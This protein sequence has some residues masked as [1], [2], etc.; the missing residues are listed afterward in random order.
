[1]RITKRACE[2]LAK[3]WPTATEGRQY[4]WD[5]TLPGFGIRGE[6]G[7]TMTFVLRYRI[8]G[9]KNQR[10]A[11]LG[12]WPGTEPEVARS[13]AEDIKAAARVGRDLLGERRA[14]QEEAEGAKRLAAVNA[15]QVSALLDGWRATIDSVIADKL[16]RGQS[17]LYERE[18]LRIEKK[19]LRPEIGSLSVAG[20]NP[21]L[22]QALVL[23]QGSPSAARNLRATIV[24]FVKFANAD[25]VRRGLTTRWP[26]QFAVEG[27][28]RSRTNLYTLEEAARIWIA[29][30]TMGRRGALI[31][32]LLLT[33][34]RRIEAQKVEWSH[35]RIDDPE[36]GPFWEQPGRLTK[37]G[38][39]HRVP[40]SVPAVALLRWL[41]PRETKASGRSDLI[42]AG[43]GGKLVGDWTVVRRALLEQANIDTGTLHDIR[44]T[45]VS[46]LGHHGFDPQVA[47]TLLNHAASNTMG[48]VMGVYQRSELWMKRREAITRWT[49]LLMQAVG[50]IMNKPVS[51][52][53]WGFNQPFT[54]AR[55]LRPERA[56]AP[57]Q[58]ARRRRGA[59]RT[60]SATQ[61]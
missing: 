8:K 61:A 38:K 57:A 34:C 43:R 14:A 27:T 52:E 33:G 2:Q 25:M 42:F 40:L 51:P 44:R 56:K 60:R 29:A 50:R 1:M 9:A 18:L 7:T 35:V 39:V 15:L 10:Y 13:A 58:A 28:A 36:L 41:P 59:G 48:G 11:K 17:V 20:L 49:D 12:D 19:T 24:R 22:F 16:A 53:I 55:I 30:G 4:F 37:N 23:L 21:E 54:D 47:D 5:D 31:R 3:A 26:T 46:T 32:W 6:S 45:I